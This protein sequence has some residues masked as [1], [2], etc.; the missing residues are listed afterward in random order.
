[1]LIRFYNT[2]FARAEEV[3]GHSYS[4]V[5]D[6]VPRVGDN[7]TLPN[8]TSAVVCKVHWTVSTPTKDGG[9]PKLDAE[10]FVR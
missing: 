3:Y 10:V 1:M 4:L 5:A 8:L 9:K 6:C 2:R 7:I